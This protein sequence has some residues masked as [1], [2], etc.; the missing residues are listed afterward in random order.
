MVLLLLNV[1]EDDNDDF[2]MILVGSITR[3]VHY[4]LSI[5][6]AQ[7]SHWRRTRRFNDLKEKFEIKI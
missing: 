1:I 3:L 4:N 7:S 2:F 5:D 6:C